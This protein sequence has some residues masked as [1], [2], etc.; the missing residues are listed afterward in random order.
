MARTPS[1]ATGPANRTPQP[2]P[3]RRTP[4]DFAKAFLAL[5]ALLG[6]VVGVPAALA[7]FAD[8][9][10][11]HRMPSL[12]MVQQ[13][14]SANVF[15][16][17]LTLVVWLA[18]AQFT[19]CVLVEVKAAVSGVGLPSRVPGA[20]PSQLLARQL[21]AAVLLITATAASFAPGLGQQGQHIENTSRP[22]V[23]AAQQLPGQQQ[24]ATVA[25][26]MQK[27]AAAQAHHAAEAQGGAVA[28]GATKFYRIQPPEG[29]HHDSLWE[30]AER[31][32][33]DGR[34]YHEIYQLN[35][36]RVQPD[37]SKLSEAS[38]IRPG[39]IMEMPA[40][41]HG[42]D[43]VEMAQQAPEVSPKLQQQIAEYAQSGDHAGPAQQGAGARPG[44]DSA[45][46]AGAQQ[47][48][49]SAQQPAQRPAQPQ[50]PQAAA[51]EATASS[52][53]S[54]FGL[55]EALIG[56]PL[57]AAG[58]LGALGRRRRMALWQSAMT[59]V[60]GRRG[61]EPPVPTGTDADVH[62]ALLI[63]AD[64]QAVRFLDQ[65]LRG[66]SAALDA[67]NRPL[68][69]VYAAWFTTT[70]LHLQ[71]AQP[72][73]EP[74]APWQRG[75][76]PALWRLERAAVP[77][78]ARGALADVAAPY[79]GLVSLGTLD[80][81]RLLLN[82]E[83]APGLVSLSGPGGARA[84][85]LSSVAA[86]L[87]T[88]GWSDR[89]TVTVVGFGKELGALAPTRLRHLD[90]VADLLDDLGAEIDRRR[91]ALGAAG[92]DSVLTG[93]TGPAQH[94]R[95]A[96]HLVMIAETP[97]QAE[98]AAL[99]E[100]TAG[101]GKLGIGCLVGFEGS[102]QHLGAAW[103]LE[104]SEEGRLTAPLLG[105]ELTA[106]LLPAQVHDAV[107]R[108]FASADTM[109]G[110]D[111][112]DP[113]PAPH[114]FLVDITEQGRPAVYARL[115]GTYEIIGLE[116][117]DG[118]RSALLHE[119]LALLL[120]HREGVH[121][122]VLASA[123]WPRGV[124]DEVRDALLGRLR[125]WLGSDED[126]SPRLR[127]DAGGRLTLARSVVSDLDVLRSL[128]YEAT[129]GSGAR[130]ASVRER[131]LTDALGLVRGPLLA[132]RPEG[133][134]GWLGHEIID[135]Q[136]P[137]LVA[138]VALALCAHHREREHPQKAIATLRTALASSPADERLWNELLRATHDTG[139]RDALLA[140]VSE[141]AALSGPRGLPPRTV[142]LLDEL[143][144]SWRGDGGPA[145]AS[146]G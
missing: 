64:P 97:D 131:L 118:E 1:R 106:Q 52:S 50:A 49:P 98:A 139:D 68:P 44:A 25:E 23:A 144:P 105:L 53:H 46:G 29:R 146:A 127:T 128:H 109:T 39:W 143:L 20:G 133:R 7:S 70:D 78:D 43:L 116:A 61:M 125:D 103:D 96:P 14:I 77:E 74:P 135:T 140:L 51:P 75:S 45:T 102:T 31:H 33:G 122:L 54:G 83:A 81:A 27:Q 99:V 104:I 24:A 37:G 93:R 126:G 3:R 141:L 87:A 12:D 123:M 63:G 57:L 119:A 72:S 34:R 10:L 19:A 26:A 124:T 71:L 56:A 115:V 9:P 66:L 36:D 42:G 5:L 6:L 18:W 28:E 117:P 95:W 59:A 13:Q 107:V 76:D 113:T 142:A 129:E 22:T 138:D 111:G 79:P 88:N 100:L 2:L 8:W 48:G 62:D 35:K 69:V 30:V 82:L 101:A 110:P 112:D 60:A 145:A 114:A 65:A 11:P 120:L 85:V 84:A 58:V 47:Q 86:E 73:G 80:G 16:R 15:V 89:M 130:R 94:T 92:H 38:L 4:G 108:L 132:D 136:L 17:I 40:D 121:P 32:L 21:I 67:A 90:S 91:S 137:L 55:S 41:A 134:Y